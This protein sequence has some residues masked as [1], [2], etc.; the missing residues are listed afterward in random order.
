MLNVV[1]VAKVSHLS[2]VI[3]TLALK[4]ENPLSANK[5]LLKP[6]QGTENPGKTKSLNDRFFPKILGFKDR[7]S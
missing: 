3:R 1:G 7:S 2:E 6:I 4:V 5:L